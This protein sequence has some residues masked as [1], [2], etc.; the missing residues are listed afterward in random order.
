MTARKARY[1][2]LRRVVDACS[3]I[4]VKDVV[5]YGKAG[6]L[7][8]LTPAP[9]EQRWL[10]STVIGPSLASSCRADI[11]LPDRVA[12]FTVMFLLSVSNHKPCALVVVREMVLYGGV[13]HIHQ[14]GPT[15]AP[16]EQSRLRPAPVV[17]IAFIEIE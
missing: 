17:V 6:I 15:H 5:F 3:P 8:I 4:V 1:K 9:L 7:K 14:L 2:D 10:F 12:L 11:T 13:A 16:V